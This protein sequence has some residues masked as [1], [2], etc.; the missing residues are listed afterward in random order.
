MSVV[1]NMKKV[2]KWEETFVPT[3]P[4]RISKLRNDAFRTP[5]ICLE[6][7]RAEMKAYEQYKSEPR[8]I[9]RARVFETYLREKSIFIM[10]DEL[11][12]GNINSKARGSQVS[13][14]LMANWMEKEMD[15]PVMGFDVRPWDRHIVHPEEKEELR[16]VILPYFKGKTIGDFNL[17]RADPEVKE[18]AYAVTASCQH[19]PNATEMAI[20]SDAGQHM[21]NYEK[22]L[23][24]GLKGI[25]EEVKWYM[26]Q[27]DQPYMHYGL[28]EKRDFYKAVLIVLDAAMAYAKRY[29]DLAREMATKEV[30]PKRKQELERIAGVCEWVPANPA[31]DWWEAVQSVW[32]IHML[33]WCE[34][35]RQAKSFGRFDQYMYPFYKKSV[36]DEKAMSHDEA[37]E[38][39][40]CFWIKTA[41]FTFLL[42]YDPLFF[43]SA[44]GYPISQCLLIGGQTR[45]GK[46]ACNEVTTLCMEAEEQV[47]LIQPEI[48]MRIWEGTPDRYLRKAVE[49]IRLGRGKMKFFGDRKAIQMAAKL[50]PDR[51]MEDWRDYAIQG[52][53]ELNLPH[54][55]KMHNIDG[56]VS[57]PKLLELVLNNGKCGLCG[58]QIGPLTGDPRT[59]ESMGALRQAFRDQAF[60]L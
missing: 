24:K 13:G 44:S 60:Y 48:A 4:D 20:F 3:Y 23:H 36:I 27:L 39:L 49:V 45:D 42:S 31:R 16:D 57:G 52:C 29:A 37:L 55:T 33:I 1:G 26:A 17:E 8:V 40:E 22:V 30:D 25:R 15:D 19:I 58:K 2:G 6:R 38:L 12:V 59:F 43:L 34:S 46:D 28:Q 11:I 53:V 5:E 50:Y 56:V 14:E 47:G 9:Q 18:K 32:M 35:T 51:S 7:A 21:D 10:E 41:T 54:I